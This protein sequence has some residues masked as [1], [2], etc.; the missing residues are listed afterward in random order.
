MAATECN[1]L[2]CSHPTAKRLNL[3]TK[4]PQRNYLLHLS[5]RAAFVADAGTGG[6]G[7]PSC[8][9]NRT[10]LLHRGRVAVL[11]RFHRSTC[12]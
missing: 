5:A 11:W 1:G 2:T 10:L 8:F 7:K 4:L 9:A 12:G 6:G 3:A